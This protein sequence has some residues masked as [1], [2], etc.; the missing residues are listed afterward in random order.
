MGGLFPGDLGIIAARPGEGKSAMVGNI[1]CAAAAE[2][3]PVAI[4]SLE[5]TKE[6][7]IDRQ[8]SRLSKVNISKFRQPKYLTADDRNRIFEATGKAHDLPVFIDDTPYISHRELIR[9]A[10]KYHR[11]HDIR[12]ILIDYLQLIKIFM[13]GRTR[14]NEIGEVTKSLK[15]LAKELSVPVVLLSQL[16]R[17]VEQRSDK[18]PQLAD[19]RDSGNVEQ[20]ADWVGFLFS[21]E[22]TGVDNKW[23]Y[24]AKNRHGKCSKVRIRWV[25]YTTSFENE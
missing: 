8:V 16:N 14:D 20:D 15:G 24:I 17:Q 21:D 5:M 2:G 13:P 10:R 18:T 1:S 3:Y 23:F 25:G 12:L 19:L 11:D 4:F 7:F 6:Q 22:Q 9:R